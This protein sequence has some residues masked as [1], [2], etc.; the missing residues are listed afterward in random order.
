MFKNVYGKLKKR[1]DELVKFDDDISTM[2]G[3]A[4]MHLL[5]EGI[6][7]YEFIAKWCIE[8]NINKV[9]DIGCAYGHQAEFFIEN[10]I[11]YAGIESERFG[12]FW[13]EDELDY[14][15]KAYPFE[16]NADKGELAISVFCLTWNCYLIDGQKTLQNQLEQLSKDFNHCLLFIPKDK[17]DFVNLYYKEHI[18]LGGNYHYFSK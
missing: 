4:L 9:Y 2:E 5:D 11:D 3:C 16:I 8:N 10:K 7:N 17:V 15:N 1:Y 14:F 12:P 13:R 18:H 6:C